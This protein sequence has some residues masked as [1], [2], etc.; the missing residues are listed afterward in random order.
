MYNVELTSN[1]KKF[2]K[3]CDKLLYDRLICKIKE[4]QKD[5]FSSDVKRVINRKEKTF[6]VRVGDYRILYIVLTENNTLLI[7]DIDKRSKIYD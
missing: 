5:P 4:L 6:R 7:S 3:K 2:L 1:S